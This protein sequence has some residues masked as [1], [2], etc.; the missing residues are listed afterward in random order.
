MITPLLLCIALILIALVAAVLV[1]ILQ[2]DLPLEP[3]P[4]RRKRTTP[5]NTDATKT[6]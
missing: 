6:P 4:P 5:K 2:D 1:D 3:P